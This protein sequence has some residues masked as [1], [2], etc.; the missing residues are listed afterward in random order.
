MQ[1]HFGFLYVPTYQC[2]IVDKVFEQPESLSYFVKASV[3]NNVIV[4]HLCRFENIY[5]SLSPF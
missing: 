1:M 3:C 4:T 2:P 5:E